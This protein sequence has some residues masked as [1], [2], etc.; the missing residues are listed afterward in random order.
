MFIPVGAQIVITHFFQSI[1]KAKI[2]IMLSL[3]RQLLFL[4]PLLAILPRYMG[5]DGVWASMPISDAIASLV[6]ILALAYYYRNLTKKTAEI[7]ATT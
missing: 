6:G 1:G 2:S 7:P 3:S 4:V 5:I